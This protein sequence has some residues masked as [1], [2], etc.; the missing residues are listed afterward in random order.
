[1][2]LF[3]GYA[4]HSHRIP[5]DKRLYLPQSWGADTVRLKQCGGP[6]EITFQTQAQLG[7]EMIREAQQRGMPY[8][9]IGGEEKHTLGWIIMMKRRLSCPNHHLEALLT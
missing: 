7:L 6:K 5:L 2:S 4:Q 8:A 1:M 9:S 3:W